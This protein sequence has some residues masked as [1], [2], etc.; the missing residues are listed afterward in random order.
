V[1]RSVF[2]FPTISSNFTQPNSTGHNKQP[3]QLYAKEMCH[4]AWDTWWSCQILT[5]FLIHTPNFF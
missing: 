3:D 1:Y 2:Q 4:A 5:G